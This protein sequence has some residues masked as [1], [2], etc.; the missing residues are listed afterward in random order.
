MTRVLHLISSSGFFGADNVLIQ[1][2]K[3]M[4]QTAFSPTIGVFK[5]LQIPHLEVAEVAKRHNFPVEIFPCKGKLDLR[6]ISSIRNVLK[7]RKIHI[8]HSHGYKSNL[9][10][11]AASAGKNVSLVATCHNWLG[12]D[13]K[14]RFYA[15]LDKFFLNRFDKVVA[16]SDTVEQEI[17]NHNIPSAKVLVIPNGIDLDRFNSL[18]K[19]D[20]LKGEF[21]I[22]GNYRVIGTVGRLS[23]EKGHRI[24]LH[25]AK[26]VLQEYSNV[27]FLIVGDG[28]LRR[29]LEAK[30]AQL[31]EA[32]GTK[33][34]RPG[35]PI[36]FAG[37][38]NDMPEIYSLMDIFVLPSLT[39]GLPMV[40]LEAMAAK[41]P[42]VA[43]RVGAVPR[44]FER[45]QCGLLIQPG[46]AESLAGAILDLLDNP[47]KAQSLAQKGYERVRDHFSAQRMADQYVEVYEDALRA[48]GSK[49]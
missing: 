47:Q 49:G 35:G 29:D 26:R 36:V 43:T 45:G 7:T 37:V 10:A 16:V 2:S 44:V 4:R 15:R 9:Y 19:P 20:T 24:L 18:R 40:L 34:D 12:D 42:A 17:L 5:N 48:R 21:G 13:R 1:L 11:L 41:K 30:S 33:A 38:R 3:Q 31:I 39:E 27:V 14:M 23:E 32:E 6:T 22:D 8:V 28:P 46:D 25:A